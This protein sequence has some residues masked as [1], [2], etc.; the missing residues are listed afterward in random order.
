MRRNWF[1]V[2]LLAGMFVLISQSIQ[3]RSQRPDPPARAGG[4]EEGKA[5]SSPDASRPADEAA[6]RAN[7]AAFVRAYNA[8]DAEAVAALFTKEARIIDK[9]GNEEGGRAAIKRTFAEIFEESPHKRLEVSVE[10]LRFLG[11]D[12]AVEVGTTN[13]VSAPG[14]PPSRDRYT[15][16]H[17]KRDG[18]WL[19][20]LAR[21]SE[22]EA[23][24]SRERLQSLAWLIGEWVDDGGSVVVRSS[25]RW[26]E[27]GNFLLQ[28]FSLQVEGRETM[29]VSQRIG[30]DPLAKRVRSWVFDSEGGFGESV[31]ARVGDTWLIKATAVRPDGT[32]AS[33]TNLLVPT[34]TDGYVWRSTDRIVGDEIAPSIEVKVVRKPPQPKE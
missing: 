3:S 31:W 16:L 6:I 23:P 21:D 12:L 17:V 20:A 24:S 1:F 4:Q 8:G 11:P 2:G 30:W 26:D 32:T 14:E 19:M 9:D 33:A 10:A 34:G 22:G 25:C 18:K 28:D 13:E 29:Q 15:V 27:G 5:E 7:I